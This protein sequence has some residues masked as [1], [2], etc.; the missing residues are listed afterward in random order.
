M[1]VSSDNQDRLYAGYA[2]IANRLGGLYT[3][4][5]FDLLDPTEEAKADGQVQAS[6]A[7]DPS[8]IAP[9]KYNKAVWLCYADGAQL[10]PNNILVGPYGTFY[11]ADK[12]P[13]APMQAIR[14]NCKIAI[15]R[16][17]Y[18]TVGPITGT[19]TN[20]A[21]NLPAFF[22]FT[23][24]DIQK[25]TSSFGAQLGRAIT[26]WDA[27]IPAAQGTLK[28]DDIV[29]DQ[30]TGINYILDAPNYTNA[31]YVVRLRLATV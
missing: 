12:Q 23:R 28:Q 3:R 7:S 13:F 19:V 14:C 17:S 20:F 26:H 27:F 6:F 11:I 9:L 5:Q 10:Q 24:E 15:G 25:P 21:L 18:S 16:V 29:V 2:R 22:Q 8:F 4:F 30:E 1:T 31:G